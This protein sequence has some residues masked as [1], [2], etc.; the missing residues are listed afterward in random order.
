MYLNINLQNITTVCHLEYFKVKLYHEW[1][2]EPLIL[3]LHPM[4][5][6]TRSMYV[7]SFQV[8][9]TV[10]QLVLRSPMVNVHRVTIALL[11]L[12]HHRPDGSSNLGVGGVCPTG[13]Y[14][15]LG[16]AVPLPCAGGTYNFVTGQPSCQQCPAGY[17]CEQNTTDP[18]SGP[19]PSGHY[20]PPGV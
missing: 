9:T 4:Y 12:T 2:P 14:C 17:Y 7:F 5:L 11:E 19:C 13:H 15:P 3:H 18:T 1:R 6:H 16:T 10:I 20:C 8:D